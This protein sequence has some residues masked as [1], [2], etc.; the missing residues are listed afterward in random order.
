MYLVKRLS[1]DEGPGRYTKCLPCRPTDSLGRGGRGGVSARYLTPGGGLSQM[2]CQ[3]VNTHRGKHRSGGAQSLLGILF[4]TP[5]PT[6]KAKIW[7]NIWPPNCRICLFFKAFGVIFCP[8]VCSY[9]CL[10]CGGWGSLAYFW[11]NTL[12]MGKMG[13]ICH[14]PRALPA[15]IW[16]HCSEVLFFTSIWGAQ[17]GVWQWHFSCCFSQHL[18]ILEPPN[19]CQ[20]RENAKWQIDP[21]LPPHINTLLSWQSRTAVWQP[22]FTDPSIWLEIAFFQGPRTAC[23]LEN[24]NLLK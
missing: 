3:S 9:F 1:Q 12:Y 19:H 13:S 23:N 10:V 18:G 24:P 20:T 11:I 14:F 15:S 8:D 4:A 16:G 6:Y 5:T 2:Q 21:F 22:R 17:K 7:T